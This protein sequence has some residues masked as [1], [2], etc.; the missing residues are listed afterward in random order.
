MYRLANMLTL[1]SGVNSFRLWVLQN[2]RSSVW[3][4]RI[5]SYLDIVVR[6][7]IFTAVVAF[8][9]SQGPP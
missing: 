1:Y 3:L 8:T 6:T 2:K 4:L 5:N 7:Y 9:Y